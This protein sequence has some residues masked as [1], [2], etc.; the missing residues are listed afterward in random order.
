VIDSDQQYPSR[1]ERRRNPLST[2]GAM[3]SRATVGSCWACF[4]PHA[5]RAV[6]VKGDLAFVTRAL[7]LLDPVGPPG[8]TRKYIEH[9]WTKQGWH[10]R[11]A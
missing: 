1:A 5:T 8:S 10:P 3:R 6:I 11:S 4:K 2:L 9:C 7:Q